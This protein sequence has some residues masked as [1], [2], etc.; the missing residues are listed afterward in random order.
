[1]I[2]FRIDW[3]YLLVVQLILKNL[4]QHNSKASVLQ[5][6]AFFYGPPLTSVHDYWK[7]TVLTIQTLVGKMMSLLFSMLSRLS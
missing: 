6:S 5:Y 1:M 3:F 2:S 4:L 7:I